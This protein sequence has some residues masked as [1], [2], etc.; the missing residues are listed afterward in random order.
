M[1]EGKTAN[2]TVRLT[3]GA[4]RLD[5]SAADGTADGVAAGAHRDVGAA[6]DVDGNEADGTASGTVRGMADGTTVG[7]AGRHS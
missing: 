4:A 6:D 5:G 3:E 1:T 7:E 2:P